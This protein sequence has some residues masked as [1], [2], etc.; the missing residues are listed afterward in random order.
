MVYNIGSLTFTSSR[1]VKIKN[2]LVIGCNF[3]MDEE[4]VSS[5]ILYFHIWVGLSREG[6]SVIVDISRGAIVI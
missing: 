5:A 3:C 1:Y 4:K 2:K 6:V